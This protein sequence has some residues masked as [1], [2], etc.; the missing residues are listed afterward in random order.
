M[1]ARG[2]LVV[3]V[4]AVVAATI[5]APAPAGARATQPVANPA[6]LGTMANGRSQAA[7]LDSL[8][9]DTQTVRVNPSGTAT[10]TTNLRPTRV[11]RAGRWVPIDTTL[12]WNADGTVS[13]AA[14]RA[15]L[16]ISGGGTGPLAA[17]DADGAALSVAWP[18]PLPR[19]LLA[20]DTARY[21]EVL[22]GIDLTVTATDLGGFSEVLVVENAAAAADPRLAVLPLRTATSGLKLSRGAGGDLAATDGAGQV[23]FTAAA[24][25]MWESGARSAGVAADVAG[26]RLTLT[27]DRALLTG[28]ATRFPV[29]IDPTW[30][31]NFANGPRQHY[32]EVQ[33]GC[34]T[35]THFDDPSST[36]THL[37]IGLQD[38]GGGCTGIYR[39][40]Y[41]AGI[42]SAIFD[43]EIV[44]A[45]INV[46]EVYSATCASTKF[47]V[48]LWWVGGI[49]KT[50]TWN[51][52]PGMIQNLGTVNWGP[53]VNPTFCPNGSQPV[54]GYDV[55]STMA[56]AA[57]GHWPAFTFALR[58]H[59]ENN[60]L[61]FRRFANN[62]SIEIEYNHPP[63]LPAS[64][65]ATAGSTNAGC[66]TAPPFP[67]IGHTASVT[68]PDL[69]ARVSDPD[70]N[71]RNLAAIF[72]F[73]KDGT[74]TTTTLTADPVTNG[75]VGRVTLPASF[76][77]GLP[78]G[79]TVDWQA[80]ASDGR[81]QSAFSAVCHF[82]VA[83][84]DPASPTLASSDGL[85]PPAANGTGATAGTAGSFTITAAAGD[86]AT[87]FVWGLDIVPPTTNPPASS[88]I[89]AGGGTA[90]LSG[91]VPRTPGPHTLWVYA[92]DQAGN[93]SGV[94]GYQFVAAAH[95]P[96]TFPS[97][98]AAFDSTLV[99]DNAAPGA[100]DGDGS[101]H[102]LSLQDLRAAGWQPGGSV[103][104]DGATI[105]LPAFGGGAP[106]NV[107]A[108]NQTIAMA[109][110]TGSTLIVLAT[111]TSGRVASPGPISGD[112]TSPFV[113][114]GTPVT[115]TNCT[116][117]NGVATDC[118]PASGTI[119]YTGAP[120]QAYFL[121]V[122]DWQSGAWDLAALSLPHVNGP[123]GQAAAAARLYAF[124][125]PLNPHAPVASITLPDVSDRLGPGVPGLHVVG[126][127]VRNTA[128][129]PGGRT[130]TGAWQSPAENLAG[131]AA[132]SW[133]AQTFRVALRPSVS[134]DTVRLRLSNPGFLSF[135]GGGDAALTIG[136][137]TVAVQS[138]GPV[139]AAAP[140]P[141]TFGGGAATASLPLGGDVYSD[142][143]A[144]AVTAGQ[145]LL[146]SFVLDDASL[147][148]LPEHR[149][150]G[151]AAEW[152]SAAGSG[153][154]SADASG[155]AFTQQLTATNLLTGVD[156]TTAAGA[157]TVAVLGDNVVDADLT[158]PSQ[159]RPAGVR[160]ADDL[161]AAVR[162]GGG[163]VFGV[164][165]AGI[166]S[167]L[168]LASGTNALGG[169]GALARLD[170]DV[171]ALPG[172]GTVV[173][174]EGL[175]DVA[176]GTPVNTLQTVVYPE[177]IAQLQAWGIT[178]ILTSLTPCDGYAKCPAAV[179]GSRLALNAFLAGQTTFLAPFV[180]FDDLSAAVGVNDPASTT[181][182]PEQ[183]LSAAADA[184]DHVNLSDAG[185]A[186]LAAAIP[187]SQLAA[188]SS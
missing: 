170:R 134:G 25:A 132:G 87:E 41:V 118:S 55:T 137:A 52:Q 147:P 27:P 7:P 156:V 88:V 140:V 89:A 168:L 28:S 38:F 43:A 94:A 16:V 34:P 164:V 39:A 136:P 173:V 12:R 36:Y 124:A 183:R 113:P 75:T 62:P 166:E 146:V 103:T 82:N 42:P 46:Q 177:L 29:S 169:V 20:G 77:A 5:A 99:S 92:L 133:G 6:G 186:S 160:V 126:L 40:Y 144:F 45:T 53:S 165:G 143:L 24:P 129:A 21:A 17:I 153:D 67:W 57:S 127:A 175:Q 187:L 8:T 108:A 104:L 90:T 48:D 61:Y 3:V 172:I 76:V 176:R 26:D 91:I 97:L 31:P 33:Q 150:A 85:F 148:V 106:D 93:E 130:W 30:Q 109:G 102:S 178:V 182:P 11:Q 138:A 56:K 96:A 1:T 181:T 116:F 32:A 58:A 141:V 70:A 2:R 15:T 122:P 73:W 161:A 66:A 10:V 167:N 19:P 163:T 135:P 68:P 121:T 14:T 154:H 184:G 179:D 162:S 115:G 174:D 131:P 47:G 86:T 188:N 171:L 139:P 83:P 13:P 18:W 63:N 54:A 180:R 185:A 155:T 117:T 60:D 51:H 105:A 114:Q 111:S 64:L 158:P 142:P 69:T 98:A 119:Q 23:R 107:L 35:G 100:A 72:H 49:D 37:G 95:A 149:L 81:A 74:T 78:D 123:S 120:Q 159:A 79:S 71:N 44:H 9:T 22:P 110:Q 59:A 152:V 84:K 65:A 50:V 4:A 157:A 145:T 80:A 112:V 128:A 101:G 151:A 125:V